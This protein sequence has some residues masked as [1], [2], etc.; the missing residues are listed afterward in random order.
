[1]G[2]QRRRQVSLPLCAQSQEVN[3]SELVK[4]ASKV[5]PRTVLPANPNVLK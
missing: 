3:T 5:Q 1:M 4:N 2:K